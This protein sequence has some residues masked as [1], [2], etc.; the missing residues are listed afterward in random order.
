MRWDELSP[1]E[2]LV[3]EQAVMNLRAFNK[4]C[5]EATDGKVLG[6]AESLAMEQGR[7]LIRLTLQ[8]S[9]AEEGA[10]VEKKVPRAGLASAD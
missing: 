1:S 7:E 2:R 3:A 9:L 4:A 10:Q 8:A 6:V 5:R